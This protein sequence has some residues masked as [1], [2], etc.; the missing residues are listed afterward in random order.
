MNLSLTRR[1]NC[2]WGYIKKSVS[3]AD[4]DHGRKNFD[5]FVS[6]L[7]RTGHANQA[8]K[9]CKND[10]IYSVNSVKVN[11]QLSSKSQSG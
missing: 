7:R 5:T 1:L 3:A 11:K 8:D 6:I 10:L 4:E 2:F 9:L